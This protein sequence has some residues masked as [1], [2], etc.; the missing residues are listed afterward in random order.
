MINPLLHSQTPAQVA[1]YKVEPYVIA[2]DVYTAHGQTGRGGWTWYTGSASWMYRVGLEGIL[3]LERRGDTL[4][5][6]PRAP[7]SWPEYRIEYRFGN[8][9]YDITVH[10]AGG[11]TRGAA[12]ITL[13]AEPLPGEAIPMI[14]DG[15]RHAVHIWHGTT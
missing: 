5:I 15:R 13:D 1:T 11:A 6:A 10:N 2:A 7:A 3:G 9:H 8:S 4:F 12:H 14:D